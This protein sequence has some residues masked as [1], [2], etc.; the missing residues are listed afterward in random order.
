MNDEPIEPFW[1]KQARIERE[2]AEERRLSAQMIQQLG[3]R[4]VECARLGERDVE[5]A[6]L[7][8]GL[9]A[10]VVECDER[11]ADPRFKA[12]REFALGVLA[13]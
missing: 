2:L 11:S 6:R 7:R 8:E 3:E 9:Q 10:I 13:K 4:D 12:I 5:C 1:T